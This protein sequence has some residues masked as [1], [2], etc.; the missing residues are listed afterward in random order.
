MKST[1]RSREQ[2]CVG[3]DLKTQWWRRCCLA[4]M[5]SFGISLNVARG[6][7]SKQ[8]ITG[9]HTHA[10]T[11]VKTLRF[12]WCR[13]KGWTEKGEQHSVRDSSRRHKPRTKCRKLNDANDAAWFHSL[14]QQKLALQGDGRPIYRKP[15]QA[16]APPI[17]CPIQI[18]LDRTVAHLK[19]CLSILAIWHNV[20]VVYQGKFT[21]FGERFVFFNLFCFDSCGTAQVRALLLMMTKKESRSR[22]PRLAHIIS[23]HD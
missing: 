7:Q 22:P 4:L 16:F 8:E 11:H 21:A 19:Y 2:N 10:H 17:L 12:F 9:A 5:S 20:F 23:L 6:E 18:P 3:C 14:Y 13:N 15:L 1:T